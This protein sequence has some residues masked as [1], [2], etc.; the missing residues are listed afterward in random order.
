MK[1]HPIFNDL[2]HRLSVVQRWGILH[3]IQRQSVAEHCHNVVRISR[4]IARYWFGI[5]DDKTLYQ[6]MDYAHHH[7]DLE[8]IMGDPPSMVKPYI[9][10]DA[11]AMDHYDIIPP[12]HPSELVKSIVKLA[13]ML[14]GYHFLCIEMSLGN[15]YASLHHDHEPQR[16]LDYVVKVWPDRKHDLPLMVTSLMNA[17]VRQKSERHSKRG[18]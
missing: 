9:S 5:T 18:R 2:D 11:M 13:D 3:T 12:N 10:E 15:S 16:I 4:R 17:M 1:R 6:I 7:D 14:E 8:A